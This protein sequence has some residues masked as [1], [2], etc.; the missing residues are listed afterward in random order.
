MPL[1]LSLANDARAMHRTPLLSI[2]VRL[3]HN[4]VLSARYTFISFI[5][6]VVVCVCATITSTEATNTVL[7]FN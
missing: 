5:Y 6:L 3:Q 7:L 1:L 4:S 2:Q